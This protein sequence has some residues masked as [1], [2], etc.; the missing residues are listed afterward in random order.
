MSLRITGKHMNVGDALS[1]RI[2]DRIG[3]AVSKYFDGGYSGSVTLEKSGGGFECDCMVHLDT[4]VVLQATGRGHEP[5]A[6]FDDAAERIE[7]RLRRYKRRLKD[8]S[9]HGAKPSA[10]A[11]YVVMSSPETE[12]EVAEDYA[13]AIIAEALTTVAELSV[14]EAV[15]QLDRTD[16]PVIVF[17]NA[18]NGKTNVVYRRADGNIGWIDPKT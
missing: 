1:E 6:V 9:N 18:G 4:G 17:T 16:K 8:H 5:G 7:K 10:E 3:D 2:E 13:P 11:A 12:E 15:M 14:A